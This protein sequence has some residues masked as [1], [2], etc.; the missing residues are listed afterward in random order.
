MLNNDNKDGALTNKSNNQSYVSALPNFHDNVILSFD[1]DLDNFIETRKRKGMKQSQVADVLGYS[2][3]SVIGHF[4]SGAKG[5]NDYGYTLFRLVTNT[6]PEYVLVQKDTNNGSLLVDVPDGSVIR[7]TRL[8][9]NGM[10]Q[11][12]MA[13]LLCLSSKTL[14]SNYE[15]NRK[16]PSIQN[17]T[18]F[19]LIT[20][21]HPT[22]S[23][24]LL[25][26]KAS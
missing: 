2:N 16:K 17:W 6:H 15:N 1:G 18:I 11:P 20:N 26:N 21:Q 9:A 7:R 23:L 14:V 25:L 13:N 4:E 10:S 5:L 24:K 19:L 22:H 12:V 8:N 3:T